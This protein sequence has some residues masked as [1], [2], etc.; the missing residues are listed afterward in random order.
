MPPPPPRPAVTRALLA[1]GLAILAA[2]RSE[3][4]PPPGPAV[5]V[6]LDPRGLRVVD[7]TAATSDLVA[8]GAGR[9]GVAEALGAAGVTLADAGRNDACGAGPLAFASAGG[10]LTL[11]FADSAFVGW[12]VDGTSA[13]GPSATATG[14][15]VGSARAELEGAYRA[16]VSETSLGSEFYTGAP[17]V[18][19]ELLS[20]PDPDATVTALWAGTVCDP[21]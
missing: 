5:A 13:D 9:G 4:P 14:L 18:P 1:S 6:F 2:C 15:G 12:S 16:D 3:P 7:S 17:G 20:G 8:F 19:G 10:A 11:S 21:R